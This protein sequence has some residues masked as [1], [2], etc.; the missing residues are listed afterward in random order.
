MIIIVSKVKSGKVVLFI[1][2]NGV[3]HSSLH[4]VLL[5]IF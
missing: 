1:C 4:L 3:S 2:L 5:F